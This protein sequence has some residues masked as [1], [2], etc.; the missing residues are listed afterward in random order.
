M[1]SVPLDVD[2]TAPGSIGIITLFALGLVVAP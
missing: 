2:K 1:F